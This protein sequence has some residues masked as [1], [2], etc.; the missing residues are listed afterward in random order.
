M[1]RIS[2]ELKADNVYKWAVI[3]QKNGIEN[4]DDFRKKM[5]E[6]I[7][8]ELKSVK[9]QGGEGVALQYLYML[10]GDDDKCKPDTHLLRFLSNALGRDVKA[11][12]AQGLMEQVVD[13][14]KSE[15]SQMKVRLLDY[16]IWSFQK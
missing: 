14:L 16:T 4:F 11:N 3:L 6:D 10:C 7:E 8:K 1:Q 5:N 2:G 12:E 9:G 15:Y 13:F